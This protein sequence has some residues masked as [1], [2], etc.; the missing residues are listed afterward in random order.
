M[1]AW[2]TGLGMGMDLARQRA[3]QDMQERA[4]A[5][6]QRR[7]LIDDS[8]QDRAFQ[9]SQEQAGINNAQQDRAFAEQ[10]QYHQ[11]MREQSERDYAD[12]TAQIARE[13]DGK[14]ATAAI[15][16][17]VSS[18]EV[19]P[20]PDGTSQPHATASITDDQIMAASP[21]GRRA[22]FDY[23]G[24][25]Q[26]MAQRRAEGEKQVQF[27]RMAGQL[28]YV[29]DKQAAEWVSLGLYQDG[30]IAPHEFPLSMRKQMEQQQEAIASILATDY[31]EDGEQVM[32][33]NVYQQ[34][35]KA[36]LEM[37]TRA[38]ENKRK[39]DASYGFWRQ[40][41][42]DHN[43]AR[44]MA[45]YQAAGMTIPSEMTTG[46][47]PGQ[48]FQQDKASLAIAMKEYLAAAGTNGKEGILA[49]PTQE[50]IDLAATAKG[51][52]DAGW[53]DLTGPKKSKVEAA[54]RKVEAWRK[55]QEAKAAVQGA[56]DPSV[57][58]S[59]PEPMGP[60]QQED[61]LIDWASQSP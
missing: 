61:A 6:Q 18:P 40:R 33:P 51:D 23:A 50:D 52:I 4:F 59:E 22:L 3:S 38:F 44:A 37:A 20:A 31:N 41:G 5:E 15:F 7:A 48:R 11:F 55:Y 13:L 28:Q 60:F 30:T 58:E 8:Q 1:S 32:D 19:A 21:E 24:N 16:R 54:K 2:M 45:Q 39:Y 57:V 53:W 12:R 36:P 26:A 17:A 9:F 10:Q 25:K 29:S 34:W 35:L 43:S 56:Y 42:Q 14:R 27:A 47:T 49:E 46:P